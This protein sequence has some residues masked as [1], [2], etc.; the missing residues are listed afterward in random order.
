MP[1]QLMKF[2]LTPKDV[3]F[4]EVVMAGNVNP[5]MRIS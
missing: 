3:V 2:Y 1:S 5:R 4:Y